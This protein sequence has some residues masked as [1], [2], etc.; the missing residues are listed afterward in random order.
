ML[1]VILLLKYKSLKAQLQ[2]PFNFIVTVIGISMIGVMDILLILV[3]VSSFKS[4]GGCG[5]WELGFMFSL[6]KMSHG[7]HQA[8]FIP[9]WGHDALV[10]EGEYD[11][12]LVRPVHPVPQILSSDFSLAA[13]GEWLPSVTMFVLSASKVQIQWNVFTVSFLALLLF[14]G[15]VIEWAVS[16]IISTFGFWV[17]RTRSLRG[18]AHSF[19]FRVNHFPAHIYG[20]VFVFVLTF[21]F[22]Y[23]FMSYY[24]THYFFNL[25]VRVYSS[26]FA[27]ATPAIAA[28]FLTI[29]FLFHSFGIQHYKSTGT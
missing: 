17:V 9:F 15:A 29:A 20:R 24:P 22:P 2:Y 25:D 8:F 18:I 23:A 28:I 6:W 4:I 12:I 7:I 11:R 21:I 1:R 5:F 14:S 3:P 16:M 10:R 13:L 19:L 27:Y 26:L